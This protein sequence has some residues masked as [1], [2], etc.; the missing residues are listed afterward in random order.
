M[1][2]GEKERMREALLG[3]LVLVL[4]QATVEELPA[5][6]VQPTFCSGAAGGSP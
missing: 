4:S 1:Q 3:K 6:F 2:P 5:P